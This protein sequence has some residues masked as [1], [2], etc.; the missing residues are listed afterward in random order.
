MRL[1]AGLMCILAAAVVLVACGDDIRRIPGSSSAE[2]EYG[3]DSAMLYIYVSQ[4]NHQQ[5]NVHEV[6]SQW[7]EQTVTWNNF[8]GALD[9]TVVATFQADE[10]GW[11]SVEVTSLVGDWLDG[12]LQTGPNVCDH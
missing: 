4:A 10:V 5:V 8:G 6:T 1:I 2:P 7:A 9:P 11:R 12:T 3:L